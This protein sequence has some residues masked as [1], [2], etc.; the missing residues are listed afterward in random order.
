MATKHEELQRIRREYRARTG[1][2]EI[3][4]RDVARFAFKLGWPK[5]APKDP[6]D[7]LAKEISEAARL[8][9][10]ID[11]KT[12]QPYRANLCYTVM[13]GEEQLTLWVDTDE[14]TRPQVLRSAT[15][16]RD[17]IV[18]EALRLANTV[19]HWN[20]THPKEEPV[21]IEL[22]LGPD[23]EWLRNAPGEDEKA[24]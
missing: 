16:F 4:H 1:K 6:V 17:Q 22:D 9:Q 3:D 7:I 8:E 13:Q 21:Q 19:D 2:K 11:R 5:P 12:G 24:G 10:R 15:K 20:R 14:A 23:V 18:G